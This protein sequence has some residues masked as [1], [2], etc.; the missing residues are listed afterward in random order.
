MQRSEYASCTR[1]QSRC[2]SRIWLPPS[3]MRRKF[4]ADFICP[5][6]GRARWMRSSNAA[7]V[8]LSASSDIAPSTSAESTRVSAASSERAPTASIACV[9]LMSDIASFASSTTGVSPAA[10]IASAPV[11]VLPWYTAAPSPISTAAK[12][13]KGARSPLAPT[14]P[15]DGITGCTPRS[16]ILQSVSTING[17]TP[18][19]PLAMEFAR[20]SIM[21]RVSASLSGSPTPTQCERIRFNCSSRIC[22]GGMRTSLS[23]PTPVLTAYATLLPASCSSTTA[24][25]FSM[26]LRAAGSSVT[27]REASQ[28]S[29]S[30]SSPRSLPLM[31]NGFIS[32]VISVVRA[33]ERAYKKALTWF[34]G[35]FG[36]KAVFR[37]QEFRSNEL[38][39]FEFCRDHHALVKEVMHELRGE[40][41]FLGLTCVLVADVR[42][43]VVEAQ[44]DLIVISSD[45]Q[46][47]LL[48]GW[49]R[50]LDDQ[51]TFIRACMLRQLRK[52][53]EEVVGETLRK[54]RQSVQDHLCL[55]VAFA[56]A[57]KYFCGSAL[58]SNLESTT[59]CVV[60]PSASSTPSSTRT[61]S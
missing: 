60:S 24:R 43:P 6:C 53:H 15:C 5:G 39:V 34:G 3:S 49:R 7:S 20:S 12:W 25:A 8:P 9:P 58:F 23:F 42:V 17:R 32:L 57:F 37:A 18:E 56:N 55:P 46:A 30:S 50:D 1:P 38:L 52:T 36:I 21:A 54:F 27:G 28:T 61:I 14:L 45:D 13:A 33:A 40:L 22:S 29:R 4:A 11:S 48:A 26:A 19:C 41:E 2:D 47:A 16:S 59:M 10:F 44:R 35:W 51:R 31:F